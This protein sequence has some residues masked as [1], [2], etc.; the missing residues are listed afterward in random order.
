MDVSEAIAREDYDS[1]TFSAALTL[2]VSFQLRAHSMSIYLQNNYPDIFKAIFQLGV[3]TINVKDVWK[4]IV[5]PRL[6][7]VISKSFDINSD[8]IITLS[9]H[10]IDDLTEAHTLNDLGYNSRR[11]R[12]P[13]HQKG[14]DLYSRKGVDNFIS[15][16]SKEDF[17]RAFDIPP[18][19]PSESIHCN[20]VSLQH[21]PIFFAGR[22]N[23]LCRDLPQT[24]WLIDG[25]RRIEN[26]IQE[27]ICVPLIKLTKAENPKFSA[28]GRED[29]DVRTLGRGRPFAIELLNPHHT[30]FS[31][32]QLKKLENEINREGRDK[33][34]VRYMQLVDKNSLEALKEGEEH[35]KKTYCAYCIVFGPLPSGLDEL[36]SLAPITVSQKTPI[37]VLHRRPIAVRSRVVHKIKAIPHVSSSES[38]G[39]S[40]FK[41][42]VTT[43]AG[44][45]IKEFVH[46]DFGRTT[47]SLGELLGGVS[48]D[49]LALDVEDISL[50]WPP[51]VSYKEENKNV[52]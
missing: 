14:V 29:V 41:L 18:K 2:P 52:S 1:K 42:Y 12:R 43:Q 8:F 39:P 40:F 22:Y 47:P 49:I 7:A 46:G 32:E 51:P 36:P 9:F 48:I 38:N 45:Y 4:W 11:I 35:K 50:D 10:Y 28:S 25:E 17:S 34:A 23:K 16:I 24:P 33:L 31:F 20:S 30:C 15:S 6:E 27:I 44:T 5:G 26:S 21:N 19:I 3:V 37:R 13:R